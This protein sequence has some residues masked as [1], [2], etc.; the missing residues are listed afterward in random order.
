MIDPRCKHELGDF[1]LGGKRAD[2]E[3]I[4]LEEKPAISQAEPNKSNSD[5]NKTESG[6][7][8]D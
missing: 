2:Y 5:L 3:P 7:E 6:R 8:N 1:G 4:K